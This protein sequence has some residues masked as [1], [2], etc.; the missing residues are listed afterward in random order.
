MLF[1]AGAVIIGMSFDFS[2]A[3]SKNNQIIGIESENNQIVFESD[4]FKENQDPGKGEEKDNLEGVTSSGDRNNEKN[5]RNVFQ[6]KTDAGWDSENALYE[7]L[8]SNL[9]KYCDAKFNAKKCHDYLMEAKKLRKRDSRFKDLY[10]KYHFEK[11]EKKKS[12]VNSEDIGRD[13]FNF[14]VTSDESSKSY[15]IFVSSE[16]SVMEMMDLVQNNSSYGF[17]YHISYGFVDKINGI[18][19]IGNM[20]WMLYTC[21]NE[22]CKLS[23]VGASDC[24]IKN[25]DKIEWRYLNWMTVNWE[26]W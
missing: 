10:K 1:V 6:S 9:K 16:I 4:S 22:I 11:K 12:D 17:S 13:K 7:D 23:S 2:K 18:E 8:K 20:S 3:E 19:N 25:W 21:K 14:V 26:S 5:I 15:E 24:K